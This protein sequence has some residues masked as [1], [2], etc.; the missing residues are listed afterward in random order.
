MKLQ[1]GSRSSSNP[2]ELEAFEQLPKLQY[3]LLWPL[4][5]ELK[6]DCIKG[7]VGKFSQVGGLVAAQILAI[8]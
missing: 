3:A 4:A 8:L 7:Y 1:G 6:Y 2:V 5:V